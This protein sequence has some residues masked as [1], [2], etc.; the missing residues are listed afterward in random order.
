MQGDLSNLEAV[1]DYLTVTDNQAD[2]LLGRLLSSASTMVTNYCQRPTFAAKA[3]TEIYDGWGGQSLQLRRAPVIDVASINFCGQSITTLAAGNPPSNGYKVLDNGNQQALQ[4]YGFWFPRQR[5]AVE[6]NYSAGFQRADALTIPT[7][8]TLNPGKLSGFTWMQ[9]DGVAF[10]S[11]AALVAV[12]S[13]PTSGQYAID[14]ATGVYT[15]S[16]ADVGQAVVITYSFAPV[17]VELVVKELMAER[18]KYRDRPG[19]ISKAISAGVG[20]TIS[21]STADLSSWAKT[22]LENYIVVT[23]A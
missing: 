12:A 10:A 22:T 5:A 3:Y 21:F 8:K 17:D 14:T 7:A 16:A 4:L 23:P 11:G 2:V 13:A 1:K 15:F 19:Q 20:E 9:D 18:Y 6:V